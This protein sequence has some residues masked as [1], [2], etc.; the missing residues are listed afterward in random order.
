MEFTSRKADRKR[1]RNKNIGTIIM[2]NY[3]VRKCMDQIESII[4]LSIP[5]DERKIDMKTCIGYYKKLML[6]LRKKRTYTEEELAEFEDLTLEFFQLWVTLYRRHGVTNYI[7]MIGVGQILGYMRRY[8]NLNK[9]S[10][11]GWEAL[12]ALIKIF[13]SV[14]QAKEESI[15]VV[16]LRV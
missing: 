15:V 7:H 10:Q 8:G 1:Q 3:K 16:N 4:D 11:Q 9:Y 13:S 12:N 14:A 6:I 5:D 2:E